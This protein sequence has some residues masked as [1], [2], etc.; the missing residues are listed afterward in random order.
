MCVR[1]ETDKMRREWLREVVVIVVVGLLWM[2]MNAE[3]CALNDSNDRCRH[4]LMDR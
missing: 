4:Y 2:D 3:S 1:G